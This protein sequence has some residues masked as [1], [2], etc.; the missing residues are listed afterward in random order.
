MPRT[1][2]RP[3]RKKRNTRRSKRSNKRS[4]KQRGGRGGGGGLGGASYH[5]AFTTGATQSMTDGASSGS[6]VDPDD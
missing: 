4:K 6:P 5:G 3:S 1:I 2:S